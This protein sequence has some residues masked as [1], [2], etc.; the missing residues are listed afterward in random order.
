MPTTSKSGAVYTSG[1]RSFDG[2][3]FSFIEKI[4]EVLYAR[5]VFNLDIFQSATDWFRDK[6]TFSIWHVKSS[7]TDWDSLMDRLKKDF[8][9]SDFND[10]V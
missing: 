3:F 10:E 7:V 8:L 1:I 2:I 4:K 6:A 5:G 9:I